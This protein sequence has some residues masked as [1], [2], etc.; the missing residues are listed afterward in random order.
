M[1]AAANAFRDAVPTLCG[2]ETDTLGAGP[3]HSASQQTASHIREHRLSEALTSMLQW[4]SRSEPALALPYTDGLAKLHKATGNEHGY[5]MS[6][7]AKANLTGVL[8]T[9]RCAANEVGI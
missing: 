6:L 4:W 9:L 1:S 8:V 5:V 2:V 7:V 3:F